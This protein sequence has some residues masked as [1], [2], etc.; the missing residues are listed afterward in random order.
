MDP[1]A[2]ASLIDL[3]DL[4]LAQGHLAQSDEVVQRGTY[5]RRGGESVYVWGG[6]RGQVNLK[7]H[8]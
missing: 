1:M 5:G 4:S 2:H 8:F 6:E 7:S 3:S